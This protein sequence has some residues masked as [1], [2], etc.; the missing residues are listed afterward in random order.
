MPSSIRSRRTD[1]ADD[2]EIRLLAR[3]NEVLATKKTDADGAVAFE[4][5]LARGEG[6]LSPALLVASGDGGDYAFL[7]LTQSA[8]DLTDR[9]VAGRDA[10]G[11]ARCLRVH[12]ARRLSH[13][14]DG[15][16]DDAA[17][18]RRRH[19]GSRCRPDHGGRAARRRRVS[20]QRGARPGHR[21]P[22]ARRADHLLGADRNLAR[23]RLFGPEGGVDRRG[24]LPGRRLCAGSARIRSH[25]Q[26]HD[27]LGR[28]PPPRSCSTAA[29]SMAR[30][31][32]GSTSKARSISPR[33]RSARAIP[34]IR[35]A[36]MQPTRRIR[37]KTSAPRAS[38]SPTC[39]RPTTTARRRSPSRST[40]CR[41]RRKPL[42]AN[43]VVRLAEPGGRAVERKLTLPI[44]PQGA[45]DRR[46]AALRRQ[47]AQRQRHGQVR[48]GHGRARRQA[49]R[50]H[51]PQMAAA[52]HRVRN[53][54][55][56]ARTAIGATSRSR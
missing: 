32:R 38:R 21:R 25:H 15:L 6:G 8:F 56:I 50:G 1:A 39:R 12:R 14:R 40:R 41:H 54:S 43:V 29:S 17:A 7:N 20:P 42:E 52:Q 24:A 33:R 23:R 3:N 55:G 46:E 4:P 16:C 30:R 36:S 18:R 51:G 9:G 19:R 10:A 22:L 47:I 48:R 28:N 11:R 44:V 45:H 27:D 34:A 13:R 37:T 53:I 26:G 49:D 2:V 35:S 5:G 31:P